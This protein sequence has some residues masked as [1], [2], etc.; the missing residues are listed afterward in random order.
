MIVLSS[1]KINIGLHI[2]R[3]RDDGFHDIA[4]LMYLIPFCDIIEIVRD[5][6]GKEFKYNH[7]GIA[8]PGKLESNLCYKAW[9]LFSEEVSKIPVKVHLHKQIPVGAGLGG[10]SS[11]GS[12]ILRGLNTLSGNKLNT[13][14]LQIMAS[15][16]GSDCA[17][18]IKEKHSFAEGRGDKIQDISV[19]LSGFFLVIF[20]PGIEVNTAWAYN[21]ANALEVRKSL[22][23]LISFPVEEWKEFIENDFEKSV[24]AAYPE[25]KQLKD[26]LY[27]SG[28]IYASMTGSGSSV[29]GL[30]RQKPAI[31]ANL[32]RYL[33]WS[34]H[35]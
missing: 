13:N 22:R 24:F 23:Q 8:V 12:A 6:Q 29:Y 3:K 34:G 11:N 32:T 19:N 15:K 4:T 35:I 17:I 31:P 1:A 25:I 9:Q 27:V 14:N 26:K 16:L 2:L 5:K 30:F 18:F 33:I 10:G 7:S 21:K 28:A 20:N